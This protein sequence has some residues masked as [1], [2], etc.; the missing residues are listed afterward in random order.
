MLAFKYKSAVRLAIWRFESE[1]ESIYIPL[2]ADSTN[3]RVI[4]PKQNACTVKSESGGINVRLKNK[5]SAVIIEI[6][7]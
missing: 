1:S 2:D 7:A 5:N 4:Y 3:A 6:K